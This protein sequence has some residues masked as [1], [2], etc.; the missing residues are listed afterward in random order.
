MATYI[1]K[2][3]YYAWAKYIMTT[4]QISSSLFSTV[5]DVAFRWDG[6]KVALALDKVNYDL[7]YVIVVLNKD[8]SLHGSYKE[9]LAKARGKVQVTG[10]IFDSSN[11]ITIGLDYSVD[12][13]AT[14]RQALVNRFSVSQT[15]EG[16]YNTQF[17]V[18][19]GASATGSIS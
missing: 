14:R 10:M 13:T 7:N 3:N 15:L 6:E 11:M 9:N 19:G 16:T 18:L 8:G 5:S 2:G 1:A 12:G 17:Y 4:D